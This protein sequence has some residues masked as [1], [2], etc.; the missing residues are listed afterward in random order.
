MNELL[1]KISFDITEKKSNEEKRNILLLW[2]SIVLQI[3]Q[4]TLPLELVYKL[5]TI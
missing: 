3:F 5:N 2:L 1:S 4:I